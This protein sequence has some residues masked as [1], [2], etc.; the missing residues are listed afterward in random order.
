MFGLVTL[1]FFCFL[2]LYSLPSTTSSH[3]RP[4][5]PLATSCFWQP[6]PVTLQPLPP[7]RPPLPV[8]L[9][10]VGNLAL[11]CGLREYYHLFFLSF[12]A[13]KIFTIWSKFYT[14][15]VFIDEIVIFL[16]KSEKYNLLKIKNIIFTHQ[17]RI[18][19]L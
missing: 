8:A 2:F 13:V 1:S 11:R 5:P 17:M 16:F 14:Y 7:L 6:L 18:I 15:S 9:V 4:T 12:F 19:C 3:C 10:F